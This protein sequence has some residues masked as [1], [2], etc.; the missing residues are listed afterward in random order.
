MLPLYISY[1]FAEYLTTKTGTFQNDE[2]FSAM[3]M[4]CFVIAW[5]CLFRHL[6][7]ASTSTLKQR[8]AT[9]S[10]LGLRL[11]CQDSR[12]LYHFNT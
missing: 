1:S 7:Y 10:F 6:R 4:L 9:L 8:H 5:A 3:S 12:D 2:I 11:T